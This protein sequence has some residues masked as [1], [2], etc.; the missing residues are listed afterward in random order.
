[1]IECSARDIVSH[2]LG[3]NVPVGVPGRGVPERRNR[4]PIPRDQ[5]TEFL[6]D[7]GRS[8]GSTNDYRGG[9]AEGRNRLAEEENAAA[10]EWVGEDSGDR[11]ADAI[12]AELFGSNDQ[13]GCVVGI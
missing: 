4:E 9:T 11:R 12:V 8:E 13:D 10:P 1:M 2:I 6:G 5:P 7:T 3:G